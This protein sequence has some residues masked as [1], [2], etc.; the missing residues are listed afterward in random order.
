MNADEI[1]TDDMIF[2]AVKRSGFIGRSAQECRLCLL[3]LL[4][5]AGA[6]YRNG[7]TEEC[8][9]GCFSLMKLDRTANKQG[10]RFIMRMIYASSSKKPFAYEPMKDFRK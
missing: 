7:Y 1:I 4:A 3:E 2:S 6:G 9:L 10:R 5:K 8:F